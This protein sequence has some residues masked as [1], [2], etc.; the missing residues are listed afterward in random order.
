MGLDKIVSTQEQVGGLQEQL[1]DMEPVLI[2]TQAEV[3]GMIVTIVKDKEEASKTQREV[4]I[5]LMLH[6]LQQRANPMHGHL[7]SLIRI[8]RDDQGT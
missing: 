6:G 5:Y 2:Q 4:T 1:T 7:A 3:E 8:T